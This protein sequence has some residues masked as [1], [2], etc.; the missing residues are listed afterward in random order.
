MSEGKR[1]PCEQTRTFLQRMARGEVF[2]IRLLKCRDSKQ[3]PFTIA[4]YFSDVDAAVRDLHDADQRYGPAGLYTTL[5]QV[6]PAL[7]SRAAN[8]L[9]EYPENT[10]TDSNIVRRTRLLFDFDPIRPPGIS[11]T[12]DQ[13]RRAQE[14]ADAVDEWLCDEF[15]WPDPILEL[16]SGNGWHLLYAIDLPNNSESAALAQRI[17]QAVS[18]RFSSNEVTVDESTFNASRITKIPGTWV[19]KGD[20]T[21]ERPW[22]RAELIWEPERR[23]KVPQA[24]LEAVAALAPDATGAP[25]KNGKATQTNDRQ[26]LRSRLMVEEYLDHYD[27]CYQKIE[28]TDDKGRTRWGLNPCPFHD[29]H[30]GQDTVIMQD[31]EGK[32]GFHCFHDRCQ[33]KTWKGVKAVIGR[34]LPGHYDPPLS[35][36]EESQKM[37]AKDLDPAI[38]I[39]AFLEAEK[40]D[41]VYRLRFWRG[42]FHRWEAGSY[43]EMR[44]SEVRARIIRRLNKSFSKLPGRLVTDAMDQAKAQALLSFRADPPQWIGKPVKRWKPERIL[45]TR[46]GLIHLPSLVAG[47]DCFLPATPRFFTPVTMA[48]AFDAEADEPSKWLCFLEQ[49]WSQDQESISTLQEWFGYCL[50]LTAV[51]NCGAGGV[52]RRCDFAAHRCAA[53]GNRDHAASLHLASLLPGSSESRASPRSA[54]CLRF[55]RHA[56]RRSSSSVRAPAV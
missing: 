46:S 34:P 29:D 53:R 55:E 32:L 56:G 17:L 31:D 27:I 11:S 54:K 22:R 44:T 16:M 9:E 26:R 30:G 50:M 1:S 8:R 2:E 47:R 38:E 42:T 18:H 20:D 23:F 4:G 19:R 49:L 15:G 21:E 28:G 33:D 43:R 35:E 36:E 7:L 40:E 25:G 51:Q 6:D 52:S 3:K 10:T 24:K 39:Q 37:A 5:N 12:D 14:V 48:Y 41:G 45:S 13:I